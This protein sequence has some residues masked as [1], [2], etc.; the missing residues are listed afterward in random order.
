MTTG[1]LRVNTKVMKAKAGQ[2]S[3]EIKAAEAQWK[4]LRDTVKASKGYWQGDASLEHQNYLKEVSDDVD[5]I[6]K[7]LKEHP[8]DLL[9]MAGIYDSAEKENIEKPAGLPTD[10]II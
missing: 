8:T 9:K 10:F 7:R 2:V 4:K 3:S 1:Q 6:F 5:R